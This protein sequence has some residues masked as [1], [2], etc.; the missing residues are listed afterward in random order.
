MLSRAL[1]GARASLVISL[2]AVVIGVVV[3]GMVGVVAGYFRGGT[4]RTISIL[5]NAVLAVPPLILLVALASILDPTMRNI[6]LALS[7]LTIPSMV[8]IARANAIAFAQRE[9]AVFSG[10]HQGG[11]FFAGNG[12]IHGRLSVAVS[13]GRPRQ[14]S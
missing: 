14:T 11:G 2:T 7:L 8:R 10:H 3:G 9:F 4:D 6:A 12:P 13:A 5:T 1:F